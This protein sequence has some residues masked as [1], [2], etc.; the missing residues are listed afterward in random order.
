MVWFLPSECVRQATAAP[1][2]TEP[3]PRLSD[4]L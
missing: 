2:F 1:L 4:L 3:G